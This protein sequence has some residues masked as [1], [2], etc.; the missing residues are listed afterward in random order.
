MKIAIVGAGFTGLAAAWDLVNA[1]H[2]VTVYEANDFPGGLAAGFSDSQWN[3]SLEH[4]Y[5]HIFTSDVDILGLVEEMGLADTV[6]FKRV[7]TATYWH[8][9]I[10]QL[11]SAVSLLLCP[12]L[13]LITKVRMGATLAFLQ[14]TA[15]WKWLETMTAQTFL[16]KTMGAEAW[17]KIWQ[18]LFEGKFGEYASV[19]NGAWFWARIHVR[20]AALGYF[21]GGFG[22]LAEQMTVR[23]QTK[24]VAF[25]FGTPVATIE[26]KDEQFF[27]KAGAKTARFDKVLVTL[28]A[29]LFAR[30]TP[31]LPQQYTKQISQLEGL[32]AVT[33][34]LELN[35]PFFSDNTYWLN[36]NETEWPFLAV[37][38]HTHFVDP[39]N[40]GG[41]HIVY[42]GH[43]CP[44]TDE[45]FK[46][47]AKQ[48]TKKYAPYLQKLSP[49]FAQHLHR[50]WVFKALFAQPIVRVNHSKQVPNTST[51]IDGLYWASMQHIYPFDRGTNYAVQLGR[52]VAQTIHK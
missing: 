40:Y 25:V 20:S 47:S 45:R 38:E 13:S 32:G 27:V 14:L 50:A 1:G 17:H 23:L 4:H 31:S 26:K 12:V 36:I 5:H 42:V 24:G 49:Q 44:P 19:V 21:K 35:Q 41:K 2:E 37:V 6:Q 28:P 48:L 33:L 15:N 16:L 34:V 3:W 22:R 30:M 29:H 10:F 51:P 39:K 43:Y 7:R 9:K 52:S 18:P 8:G 46:V 11:D